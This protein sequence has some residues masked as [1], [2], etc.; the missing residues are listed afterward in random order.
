MFLEIYHL[1]FTLITS[2]V[3]VNAAITS[4]AVRTTPSSLQSTIEGF[5]D[6]QIKAIKEMG[7]GFIFDWDLNGFNS[8]L[9]FHLAQNFKKET[10]MLKLG[11]SSL[12]ITP[13]LVHEMIGLP[14]G[15]TK[16]HDLPYN[17]DAQEFVYKSWKREIDCANIGSLRPSHLASA[18]LTFEDASLLF[19]KTFIIWFVSLVIFCDKSGN[20]YLKLVKRILS[21]LQEGVS[22]KQI[23]WSAF[24]CRFFRKSMNAYTPTVGGY[25]FNGPMIVMQV[26]I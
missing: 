3:H 2:Y 7:F 11:T 25:H 17:K 9:S 24:V 26:I 18:L 16:F 23:D 12:K 13:T 1:T 4:I 19:K 6:C 8:K 10:L 14:I 15:G 21:C 5:K 22:I 20:C